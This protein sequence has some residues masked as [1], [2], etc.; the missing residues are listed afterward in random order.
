MSIKVVISL[1]HFNMTII[2]CVININMAFSP[3]FIVALFFGIIGTALALAAFFHSHWVHLKT[4][5]FLKR[6][7]TEAIAAKSVYNAP[8]SSGK[9]SCD[10]T[11]VALDIPRQEFIATAMYDHRRISMYDF[12]N[13]QRN[14][15]TNGT[16]V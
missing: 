11:G 8:L 6:S 2:H 9:S 4:F 1:K 12:I 15:R 7:H 3:E 14:P 13:G 10:A 16:W 5:A